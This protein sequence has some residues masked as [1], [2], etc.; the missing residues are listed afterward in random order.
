MD[1]HKSAIIIQKIW[2]G[3]YTRYKLDEKVLECDERNY[4]SKEDYLSVYFLYIYQ[5][6]VENYYKIIKI[7]SLFRM[8]IAKIRYELLKFHDNCAKIIQV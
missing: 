7:Q 5:L 6:Q 2:R 3:Y 8:Y 4:M 1:L